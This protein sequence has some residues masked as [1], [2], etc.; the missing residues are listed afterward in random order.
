MDK[1]EIER[2]IAKRIADKDM[3][4][5]TSQE[6]A[7]AIINEQNEDFIDEKQMDKTPVEEK[8]KEDSNVETIENKHVDNNITFG[9]FKNPQELLRAYGELEKEFTRR[10]QKLKELENEIA[11]TRSADAGEMTDEEM[12]AQWKASVDKFFEQTPSAKV[13]AKDIA[14]KI[15]DN[16]MLKDDPNCL[17]IA[18]NQVLIDKF[19]TPEQL[20]NDGQFLDEY[21]FSSNAIRDK[22]IARYL[23]DVRGGQPPITLVDGGL[24]T[25]APNCRPKS[26]Q[27][28]GY[29]FLKNNK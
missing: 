20:V 12:Q 11:Q 19:R 24:G 3:S 4:A 7:D 1:K 16:P 25:V 23:D 5:C 13:F 22:I 26:I 17:Q 18:L 15:I 14:K 28:A 9:K 2:E 21:V 29:M 6:I 10:S 8:I 27:E